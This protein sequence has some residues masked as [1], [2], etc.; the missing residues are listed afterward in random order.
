MYSRQR[1]SLREFSPLKI[2]ITEDKNH[3]SFFI[4]K[5]QSNLTVVGHK[6][7]ARRVLVL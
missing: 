6:Q 7:D 3:L 5:P 4:K 1:Q 2:E